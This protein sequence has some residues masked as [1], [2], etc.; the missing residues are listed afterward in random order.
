ML[1]WV[2]WERAI[3]SSG[4]TSSMRRVLMTSRGVVRKA[5]M[6]PEKE[7]KAADRKGLMWLLEPLLVCVE[8][9]AAVFFMASQRGNWMKEKG[10]SRITVVR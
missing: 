6:A 5:A 10:T 1:V 2:T 9:A 3:P 7:P 4:S 8:W